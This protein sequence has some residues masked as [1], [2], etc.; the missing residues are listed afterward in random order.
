ML[1]LRSSIQR[2]SSAS[3]RPAGF[4]RKKYKMLDNLLN[5]MRKMNIDIVEFAAAKAIFFLNPGEFP[6]FI[7]HACLFAEKERNRAVVSLNVFEASSRLKEN[8]QTRM[9]FLQTFEPPL[10]K[11]AHPSRTPSI[12]IWSEREAVKKPR[13]ASGSFSFSAPL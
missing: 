11:G 9:T 6:S 13:T 10:P 1:R 4:Q 12:A 3:S 5:P 7:K 2:F 8:F